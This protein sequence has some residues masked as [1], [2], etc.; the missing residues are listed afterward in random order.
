[1][2]DGAYAAWMLTILALFIFLMGFLLGWQVT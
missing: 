2:S 1:M